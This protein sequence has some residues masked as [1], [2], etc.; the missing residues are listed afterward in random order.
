MLRRR[1]HTTK[2]PCADYYF[3]W[4]VWMKLAA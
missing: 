3:R 1:T 2:Q 4:I